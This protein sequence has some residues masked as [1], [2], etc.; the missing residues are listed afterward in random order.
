MKR[1]W[2]GGNGW[3]VYYSCQSIDTD[4]TITSASSGDVYEDVQTSYSLSN[5]AMKIDLNHPVNGNARGNITIT[6]LKNGMYSD[7]YG[8]SLNMV[9]G[10]TYSLLGVDGGTVKIFFE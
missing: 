2:H 4:Y 8:T 5:S 9:E 7:S 3:T 6:A 10:D 1:T